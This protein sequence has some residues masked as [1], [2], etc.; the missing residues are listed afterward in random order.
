MRRCGSNLNRS[1]RI[2]TDA[3]VAPNLPEEL[4]GYMLI[5]NPIVCPK[6]SRRYPKGTK[7]CAVCGAELPKE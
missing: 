4:A 2:G 5:M 7:V 3:M 1:G 6:C